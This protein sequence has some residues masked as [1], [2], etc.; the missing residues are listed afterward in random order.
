MCEREHLVRVFLG[1]LIFQR[2][3]I[4]LRGRFEN[5]FR[6]SQQLRQ[7][8]TSDKKKYPISQVQQQSNIVETT[9][10]F[11]Q[12]Q[13]DDNHNNFSDYHGSDFFFV[14]SLLLLSDYS[15]EHHLSAFMKFVRIKLLQF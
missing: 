9:D 1:N 11:R 7:V 15:N 2:P 3:M 13:T 12:S 5:H 10:V 14:K 4:A 6:D 8:R